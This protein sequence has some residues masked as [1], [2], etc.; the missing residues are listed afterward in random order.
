MTHGP[1]RANLEF[2]KRFAG[3]RWSIEDAADII[4]FFIAAQEA[5]QKSS[6]G[7]PPTTLATMTPA[8]GK[9]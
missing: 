8:K 2:L 4:D 7:D 6:T 5:A 9:H 3:G 1:V